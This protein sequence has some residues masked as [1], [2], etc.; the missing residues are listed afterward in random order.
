MGNYAGYGMEFRAG[1]KNSTHVYDVIRPE[2]ASEACTWMLFEDAP[3]Q[4]ERISMS[5]TAVMTDTLLAT[6]GVWW[7]VQDACSFRILPCNSGVVEE[8]Q[9]TSTPSFIEHGG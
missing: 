9:Y 3:V 5:P 7:V 8:S 2:D 6:I 1:A 4:H